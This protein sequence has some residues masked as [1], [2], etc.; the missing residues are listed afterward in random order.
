M[1]SKKNPYKIESALG[2]IERFAEANPNAREEKVKDFIVRHKW[3]VL[4]VLPG[5]Y[6]NIK[7]QIISL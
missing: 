2:V 4:M 1:K 7:N 3:D 6:R 5:N